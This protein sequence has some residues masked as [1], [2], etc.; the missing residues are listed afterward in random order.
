MS[1]DDPGTAASGTI[2]DRRY[3]A[4][5]R[6]ATFEWLNSQR[7]ELGD[8]LPRTVLV[9]GFEFRGKR[10]YVIGPQGIFKPA[11]L[12]IPLSITTSPKGP[13]RDEFGPDGL[14]RYRYRETGPDHRDNVG[15]REAMLNG[16]PLVYFHG[17]LPGRYVAVWPVFVVADSRSGRAFSIA[18]DDPAHLGLS[19]GVGEDARLRREYVTVQTRRRLHQQAFRERVLRA[20]QHQCTLCQ[21][22]RDELLDAAHIVPDSEPEG[23][24]SVNNGLALCRLHHAAFDRFFVGVRPN[25]IIEVR[26]DVMADRDGPTLRHAIQGLNGRRIVL[27]RRKVDYP[28]AEAL[29]KRYERFRDRAR[30]S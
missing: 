15:L 20:Y 29:S 24:A 8:V 18:V 27:P 5:V 9:R 30:A 10:I 16:L 4:Q 21:L 19:G 12:R 25:Y 3:D 11:A 17:V 28:D 26:Q 1:Y 22:R 7:S 23:V 13:Y 14:L 2:F 6:T